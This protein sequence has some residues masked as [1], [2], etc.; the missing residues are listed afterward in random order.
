MQ[1]MCEDMHL[2]LG[3]NTTKVPDISSNGGKQ[4]E[5]AG[6]SAGEMLHAQNLIPA[7]SEGHS[8]M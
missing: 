2:F 1:D 3:M 6:S 5:H 7:V 4:H 8:D